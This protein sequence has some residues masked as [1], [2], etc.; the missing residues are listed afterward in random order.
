MMKKRIIL[1]VF[2]GV[3]LAT[4]VHSQPYEL[5]IGIRAGYTNGINVN[6]FFERDRALG[7]LAAYNAHGFQSTFQYI[8]EFT[9]YDKK[10][11]YYYFGGGF[12]L[13]NWDN[14]FAGGVAAMAG[15]EFVMREV[16][17][18]IGA[19]WKPM[20]NIGGV[21]G[22]ELVDFGIIVRYVFD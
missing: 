4:E 12:H 13:G 1:L 22:Y 18:V 8:Y 19:E 2:L 17:L 3:M 20:L 16:P 21:F 7:L 10:R 11:L 6:Y 14:A 9:P 15:A 5:G